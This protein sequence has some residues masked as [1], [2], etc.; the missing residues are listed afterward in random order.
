MITLLIEIIEDDYHYTFSVE[1]SQEQLQKILN[2]NILPK[3]KFEK[4]A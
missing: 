1:I 2:L 4:N 3:F